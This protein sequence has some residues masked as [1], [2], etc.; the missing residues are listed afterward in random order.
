MSKSGYDVT[1]TKQGIVGDRLRQRLR[2]ERER[3]GWSQVMLAQMLTAKGIICDAPTISRMENGDR[4][5]HVETLSALA[6]IFAVSIDTL[7]GRSRGGELAWA[8]GNLTSNAQK[9][10]GEVDRLRTRLGSECDDVREAM[11]TGGAAVDSLLDLGSSALR[12]LS[13]AQDWLNRLANQFPI[14]SNPN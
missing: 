8:A 13:S 7:I 4:S 3:H 1:M 12:A 10:A 14:P 9:M 6:D 11:S 2:D 5:I